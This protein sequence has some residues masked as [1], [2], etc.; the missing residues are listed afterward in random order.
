MHLAVEIDDPNGTLDAQQRADAI[1]RTLTTI[2][3]RINQ[4]GVREPT[5]QKAGN[6]RIIM[7]LAGIENPERAK[8]VMEK[9]A[10]LEFKIVERGRRFRRDLSRL[11]RAIVDTSAPEDLGHDRVVGEGSR[12][13]AGEL[14]AGRSRT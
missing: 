10:F 9:T 12:A 5:I 1:D 11:D 7:E 13:R 2:R 8:E 4:F 6:D 3:N 14:L